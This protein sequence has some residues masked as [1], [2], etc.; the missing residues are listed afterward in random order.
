ML[1]SPAMS[2]DGRNAAKFDA[3]ADDYERLHAQSIAASGEDTDYFAAYKAEC[4][5]RS[6]VT[7]DAMLLDFGCG[8]GNVTV[9][10]LDH[11]VNVHAF[12]PSRASAEKARARAPSAVIHDDLASVPDS[13]YSAAVLSCVLHH[14]PPL[15]RP[16]VVADVLQK[17]TPGGR[18]F[19]FEHNPI[20]PLTRRSV[21]NCAFD[22][23]AILLWPWEVRRLLLNSGY[24]QV[25]LDYI[26]FFPRLLSFMRPL[27]PKLRWLGVGAQTMTVGRRPPVA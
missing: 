17:L 10:L 6:G 3:I 25:D 7:R 15:E 11:F 16:K 21:K 19:V 26:V 9:K 8:I 13:T 5:L 27:E 23:D 14:V 2:D 12:E 20:N 18:V 4:L 22:D 24:S 1:R